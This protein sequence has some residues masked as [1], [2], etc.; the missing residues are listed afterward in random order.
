RSDARPC[1]GFTVPQTSQMQQRPEKLLTQQQLADE[2]RRAS[3]PSSEGGRENRGRHPSD[4]GARPATGALTSTPG[5]SDSD[6]AKM[7]RQACGRLLAP[8]IRGGD[9]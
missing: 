1:H 7:S 6:A 3:A 2:L 5:W 4:V 9:S 8:R